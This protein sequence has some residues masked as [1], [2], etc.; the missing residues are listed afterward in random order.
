MLNLR[1]SPGSA[2]QCRLPSSSQRS[3]I[4]ALTRQFIEHEQTL[5][6]EQ[7]TPY[8]APLADLLQQTV[9]HSNARLNGE[10]Q[11]RLAAG[12]I[13][14]LDQQSRKVV[15][16]IWRNLNAVFAETP[17]LAAQWGFTVKSSGR[18]LMP[19]TRTE[20]LAVLNVYISREEGRPEEERF[21]RPD[22][23]EVIQVR[24]ELEAK[25]ADRTAGRTRREASIA[26]TKNLAPQMFNLLQAAVVHLWAHEFNFSLNPDLQKWGFDVI[27]RRNGKHH[28]N[29]NGVTG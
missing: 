26:A 8:T 20:R 24:D 12:A 4:F 5:L 16:H 11:R 3:K 13:E 9:P 10:T 18:I 23:A 2:Y 17:E 29:G 21:S 7:Q 6:P 22:L 14:R 19:R 25:L 15:G 27:E 1:L 28:T